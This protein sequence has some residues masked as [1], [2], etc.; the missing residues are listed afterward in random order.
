MLAAVTWILQQ[1][2]YGIVTGADRLGYPCG[3]VT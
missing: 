3:F 2:Q 1:S